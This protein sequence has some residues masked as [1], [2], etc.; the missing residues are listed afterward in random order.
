M[1]FFTQLSGNTRTPRVFIF[2]TKTLRFNLKTA[3]EILA[4]VAKVFKMPGVALWVGVPI[5]DRLLISRPLCSASRYSQQA[6]ILSKPLFSASPM[7]PAHKWI[8]L[9]NLSKTQRQAPYG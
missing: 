3:V 9:K 5:I 4:S 8:N 1:A 7:M 6:A 2:L